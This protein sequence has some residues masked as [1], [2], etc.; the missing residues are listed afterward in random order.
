MI[1]AFYVLAQNNWIRPSSRRGALQKWIIQLLTGIAWF[2]LNFLTFGNGE[3][4]YLDGDP[5]RHCL[6]A[7]L[8]SRSFRVYL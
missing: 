7:G 6:G 3:R 2:G 4:S 8:P 5:S 1:S